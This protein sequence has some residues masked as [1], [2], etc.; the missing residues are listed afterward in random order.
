MTQS[1]ET[2]CNTKSSYCTVTRIS[3][4]VIEAIDISRGESIE[5][6]PEW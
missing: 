5:A 2:K 4:P 6:I 3:R 1:D